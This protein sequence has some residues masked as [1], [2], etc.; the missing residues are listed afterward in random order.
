MKKFVTALAFFT[1]ISLLACEN[2][3]MEEKGLSL[4]NKLVD[5]VVSKE[6]A[7]IP[8]GDFQEERKYLH[9]IYVGPERTFLTSDFIESNLT[10]IILNDGSEVPLDI[11]S[12]AAGGDMGGG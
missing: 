8:L 1:S 6:G 10:S 11:L 7:Y 3:M 4:P 9:G 12:A 5:A 2:G